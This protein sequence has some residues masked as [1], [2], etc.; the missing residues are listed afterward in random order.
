[1]PEPLLIAL[2]V[3]ALFYAV[4]VGA[5]AVAGR[6]TDAAALARF[7]PDCVVLLQRLLRDRRVPRRSRIVLG[8]L[9]AY[10]LSPLDLVPDFVPVAGHL[11]DAL[12]LALA[13]RYLVA[14]AGPDVVRASWPGPE[15]SVEAILR[16]AQRPGGWRTT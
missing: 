5:L 16:L 11:D 15:R 6:R 7:I 4:A 10:L 8:L 9:L 2:L 1:M 12:V 3:C 13:L 14:A